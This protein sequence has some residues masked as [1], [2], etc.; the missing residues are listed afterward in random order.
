MDEIDNFIVYKRRIIRAIKA[1]DV[2]TAYELVLHDDIVHTSFFSFCEITRELV[3]H[4]SSVVRDNGC[5]S[6]SSIGCGGG[7]L[8]WFIA[9]ELGTNVHAV[10]LV[11]VNKGTVFVHVK[12]LL[13]PTFLES[14]DDFAEVPKENALLFCWCTRANWREYMRRYTGKVV[15]FVHPEDAVCKVTEDRIKGVWPDA[16]ILKYDSLHTTVITR[17]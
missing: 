9:V 14:G 12:S 15:I 1:V 7:L 13:E 5:I 6:L 8:E 11:G 4:I 2:D 3:S 10:D 16:S 17:P